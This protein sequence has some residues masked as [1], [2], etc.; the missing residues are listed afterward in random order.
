M[1]LGKREPLNMLDNIMAD[2]RQKSREIVRLKNER[3]E[4]KIFFMFVYLASFCG[5]SFTAMWISTICFI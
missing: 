4:L 5:V 2:I 3:N 1:L